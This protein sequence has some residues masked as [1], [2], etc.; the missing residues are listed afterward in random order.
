[1]LPL[2]GFSAMNFSY[3]STV[4]SFCTSVKEGPQPAKRSPNNRVDRITLTSLVWKLGF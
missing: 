4:S 2:E 3:A 1:M